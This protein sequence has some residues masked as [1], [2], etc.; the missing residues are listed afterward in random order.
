MNMLKTSKYR[1][2]EQ[3]GEGI[4]NSYKTVTKHWIVLRNA[5]A[6]ATAKSITPMCTY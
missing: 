5:I 3:N 1:L 6:S 4:L 2:L